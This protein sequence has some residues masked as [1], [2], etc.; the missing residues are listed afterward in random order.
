MQDNKLKIWIENGLNK[1]DNI[2]VVFIK[3]E[4]ILNITKP[5]NSKFDCINTNMMNNDF[6]IK[7]RNSII[8]TN[9]I[10]R[11]E[12]LFYNNIK[13]GFIFIENEE[14]IKKFIYAI[15]K[16]EPSICNQISFEVVETFDLEKLLGFNESHMKN[17][18]ETREKILQAINDKYTKFDESELKYYLEVYYKRNILIAS[19][20]QKLY[21]LAMLDFI[22]SAKKIGG[23]LS[24]ILSTS[25]KTHT[26]KQ[27]GV[28]FIG[29]KPT[30][31]KAYNLNINEVE[32]N[33]KTKIAT[34]LLKL[35]L[36]ELDIK[37]ISKITDLSINQVE[38][39]YK[40]IFIK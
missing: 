27:I 30:N 9:Q 24:Y 22:S 29:K 4:G 1:V 12:K 7:F 26:P 13:D 5:F 39:I 3:Y 23:I 33:T 25:S 20:I 18:I 28:V 14:S 17:F 6:G 10:Y 19:F 40:K 36:K 32:L 35:N 8:T 15:E 2:E 31:I 16:R 34:N 11:F 38:K 21:R 37:Q